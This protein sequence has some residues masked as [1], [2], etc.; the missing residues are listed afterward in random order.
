MP[1]AQ[2]SPIR[3]YFLI[4]AIENNGSTQSESECRVC[5]LRMKGN[6]ASNMERHI[7]RSHPG[8]YE[9]YLEIKS[10]TFNPENKN[11]NKELSDKLCEQYLTQFSFNDIAKEKPTSEIKRPRLSPTGFLKK[12]SIIDACVELVTVN[13]R[14]FSLMNDSGFKMLIDPLINRICPSLVIDENSIEKYVFERANKIKSGLINNL[15]NK[16]IALKLDCVTHCNRSFLAIHAQIYVRIEFKFYT[17]SILEINAKMES[18]EL[19]AAI[20]NELNT[21]EISRSQIYSVTIDGGSYFNELSGSKSVSVDSSP[22]PCTSKNGDNSIEM[23]IEQNKVRN[24]D[25]LEP[26]VQ[27][28]TVFNEFYEEDNDLDTYTNDIILEKL[29]LNTDEHDEDD[30]DSIDMKCISKMLQSA[31]TSAFKNGSEIVS[32]VKEVHEIVKKLHSSTKSSKKKLSKYNL[33]SPDSS[34]KW[35]LIHDKIEKIL[36]MK[37][38]CI[39]LSIVGE[40]SPFWNKSVQLL[41][42]LKLYKSVSETIQTEQLTLCDVYKLWFNCVLE[43]SK[44]NSSI[45]NELASEM[46]QK[47]DSLFENICFLSSV[48]LDPRFNNMVLNEN[49]KQNAVQHLVWLYNKLSTMSYLEDSDSVSETDGEDELEKAFRKQEHFI[50]PA[51]SRSQ[52]DNIELELRSFCDNEPRLKTSESI[53]QFWQ[54]KR[55]QY[56]EIFKLA[57][58]LFSVPATQKSIFDLI[59]HVKYILDSGKVDINSEL[60]QSVALI[61]TNSK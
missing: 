19:S 46:R 33:P 29:H 35:K 4:Q 58:V 12:E 43:I 61:K 38:I 8:I 53:V 37:P 1:K 50:N 28:V 36:V 14:P 15:R 39:Q 26:E 23:Q 27:V 25:N 51:K 32:V 59:P 22:S 10:Q 9:K 48:F 42:S 41:R 30:F 52:S 56:P 21:F 18:A 2:N 49:Q 45:A 13:G 20:W 6:H 57:R 7:R 44:L 34:S 31:I 60:F 5:G 55:S 40:S 17:L 47:Q 54:N 24:A 3:M 11:H 16:M